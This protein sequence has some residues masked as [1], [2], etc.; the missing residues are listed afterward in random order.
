VVVIVIAQ[1]MLHLSDVGVRAEG[2]PRRR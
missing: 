1:E 2:M